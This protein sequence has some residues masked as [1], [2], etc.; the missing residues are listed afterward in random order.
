MAAVET[1]SQDSGRSRVGA[2]SDAHAELAGLYG[3]LRPRLLNRVKF[4]WHIGGDLAE[5]L[6]HDA[7][8]RA[9]EHIDRFDRDR[10]FEP[11]AL[12]ILD[13]VVI[14]HLRRTRTGTGHARQLPIDI[15][16]LPLAAATVHEVDRFG[17]REALRNAMATL[18]PRQ[19]QTAVGVLIDGLSLAEAAA[20]MDLTNSACRQLLHRARIG[21]RRALLD[22]GVLPVFVP[23]LWLRQRWGAVA[24]RLGA[25]EASA[26]AGSTATLVAL[27]VTVTVTVGASDA[28]ARA[29]AGS[30]APA[31]TQGEVTGDTAKPRA[32][33]RGPHSRS[34]RQDKAAP[35]GR[36][37]KNAVQGRPSLQAQDAP[38]PLIAAP[39]A[40]V[41]LTG[42]RV[43]QTP[44]EDPDYEYGAAV[45]AR[46]PAG[47]GVK[48]T[49]RARRDEN[50]LL[51]DSAPVDGAACDA[52]TAVPGAY[53]KQR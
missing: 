10:P 51:H 44:M 16:D 7:W 21:L 4:K 40:E 52:A 30:G 1:W 46:G 37:R 6:V 28:I 45:H 9:I 53:C 2:R 25:A 32:A 36:V 41:P 22:Q 43:H 19:Q 12:R 29:G 27:V 34:T 24:R 47:S 26:V 49:V 11:W 23:G 14:D 20:R 42:S 38:A 50:G 18:P 15:G 13:N 17:D 3:E 31:A 48:V 39:S 8:V 33:A 5:D 35:G